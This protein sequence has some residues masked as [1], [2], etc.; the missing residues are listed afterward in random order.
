M[1]KDQHRIVSLVHATVGGMRMSALDVFRVSVDARFDV[2]PS[3]PAG[4]CVASITAIVDRSPMPV[5]LIPVSEDCGTRLRARARR[6]HGAKED[7][8]CPS[9]WANVL[10]V[11][12]TDRVGAGG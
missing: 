6:R 8:T 4:S 9:E 11:D 1:P 12:A 10:A 5:R 7:R 3:L 2:L